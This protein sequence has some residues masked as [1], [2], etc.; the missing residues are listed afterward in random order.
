M[1]LGAIN[2]NRG[3]VKLISAERQNQDVQYIKTDGQNP[4]YVGILTTQ[5]FSNLYVDFVS[6]KSI[7]TLFLPLDRYFYH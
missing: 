1:L 4:P 3:I 5:Q 6:D 7:L 2:G